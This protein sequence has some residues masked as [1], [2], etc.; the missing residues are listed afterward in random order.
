M[1]SRLSL[2]RQAT[3]PPPPS[4]DI[5]QVE[6]QALSVG[7]LEENEVDAPL[8]FG[9]KLTGYRF[10]NLTVV[11]SYGIAKFVLSLQGQSVAPT[12]LDWVAGSVLAAL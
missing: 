5:E 4:I 1:E 7:L 6:P 8:P 11:L 9:V 10:V 2:D 12:A 3:T